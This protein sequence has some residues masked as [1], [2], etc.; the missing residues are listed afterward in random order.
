MIEGI[1]DRILVIVF[2]GSIIFLGV[3]LLVNSSRSCDVSIDYDVSVDGVVNGS[4][5][6]VL[7]EVKLACFK[8]CLDELR[9]SDTKYYN[10]MDACG[11]LE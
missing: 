4:G 11:G 9:G 6:P 3:S 1:F 8:L 2:I 10:C 7:S 5:S